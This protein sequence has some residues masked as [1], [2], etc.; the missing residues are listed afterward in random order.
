MDKKVVMMKPQKTWFFTDSTER[1]FQ[2][3]E[4]EAFELLTNTSQWRRKDIKMLGMSDGLTY[5]KTIEESK[6]KSAE[7]SENIKEKKAVLNKYVAGHDKLLF[8][9]FVEESDPRIIRAKKLIKEQEEIL[10]PLEKEAKE[11]KTNIVQK[12]FDAELEVAR[13]NMVNPKDFS[14]IGMSDGTAR[15][16]AFMENFKGA[17]RVI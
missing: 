6:S 12:A 15:G 7:L 17:K 1:I 5:H 10:E 14:V 11:I 2:V 16:D 3:N 4:K 13:G 8:E 9:N